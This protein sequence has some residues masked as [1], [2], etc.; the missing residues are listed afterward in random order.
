METESAPNV[1]LEPHAERVSEQ[2]DGPGHAESGGETMVAGSP[3]EPAAARSAR[4]DGGSDRNEEPE[5]EV[6][7]EPDAKRPRTE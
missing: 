1:A 6:A 5:G 7:E 4:E 2:S 3:V